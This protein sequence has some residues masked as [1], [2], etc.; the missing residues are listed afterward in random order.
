MR[1]LKTE[2]VKVLYLNNNNRI[3]EISDAAAGTVNH[4]VP[5]VREI[6]HGALQKYAAAI[7]SV[8]NHPSANIAPSPEDGRFTRN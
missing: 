2:V 6:I 8:H 5:I 1:D 7:I 3:I 4:A